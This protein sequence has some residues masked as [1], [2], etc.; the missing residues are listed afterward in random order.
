MSPYPVATQH[1]ISAGVLTLKPQEYLS[2]QFNRW[3]INHAPLCICGGQTHSI[4]KHG[5]DQVPP[6]ITLIH[7]PGCPVCV[8][9]VAVIDKAVEIAAQPGVLFTSFGDM[10]RVP[11]S[12][13][14]LFSVRASEEMYAWS[15]RRWMPSNSHASIPTRGGVLRGRLKPLHQPTLWQSFRQSRRIR[16]FSILVSHVLV[17]PAMEAIFRTSEYD[18][19]LS[20]CRSCLRGHGL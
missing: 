14:D 17:P 8:T 2:P 5:I 15:T 4:I 18:R 19:R 3:W 20:G 9:P 11:G 6:E 1:E 10:L 16:N 12:S 7:G 13:S